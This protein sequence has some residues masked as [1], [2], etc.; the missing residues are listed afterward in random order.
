MAH[1]SNLAHC[2]FCTVFQAKSD[3]YIFK[4]LKKTLKKKNTLWCENL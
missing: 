3:V 4:C 2:P 1:V